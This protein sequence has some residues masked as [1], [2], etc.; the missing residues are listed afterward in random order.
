MSKGVFIVGSYAK[1]H[2]SCRR[3]EWPPRPRPASA[4]R[5]PLPGPNGGVDPALGENAIREAQRPAREGPFIFLT[6]QMGCHAPC[7]ENK[8]FIRENKR[9]P[10]EVQLS[11]IC[12]IT[13]CLFF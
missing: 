7:G 10:P 1:G 4:S 12:G 3:F 13:V 6:A 2:V 8:C 5:F 9:H 11:K